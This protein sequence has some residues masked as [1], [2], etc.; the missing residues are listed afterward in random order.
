MPLA[1]LS[2]RPFP[3][4]AGERENSIAP[5]PAWCTRL[6]VQSAK[7]DLVTFQLRFQFNRRDGPWLNAPPWPRARV[8]PLPRCLYNPDT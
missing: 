1:A 7:A 6:R 8:P 5:L 3:P 4:Q 2:P